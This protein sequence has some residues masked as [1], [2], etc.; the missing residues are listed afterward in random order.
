MRVALLVMLA[1]CIGSSERP[2]EPS[3]YC[4]GGDDSAC[5]G[6]DVCARNGYCYAAS[7]IRAVQVTWT[8]NGAPAD[9]TTCSRTPNLEIDFH[10]ETGDTAEDSLAFAPVPCVAGKFSIDKLPV[11]FVNVR[12][13]SRAVSGAGT[14][15]ASGALALDLR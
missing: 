4:H 9:A 7:A 3:G 2:V 12:L 6:S 5:D 15:D 10:A 11:S 8:I 1:G 13:E 14:I